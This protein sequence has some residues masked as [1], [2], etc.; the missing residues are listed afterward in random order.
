MDLMVLQYKDDEGDW[1]QLTDDLDISHAATLSSTI[2]IQVFDKEKLPPP[3]FQ[4]DTPNRSVGNAKDLREIVKEL[5]TVKETVTNLLWKLS[6]IETST[7]V[8]T[9]QGD[10]PKT[11]DNVTKGFSFCIQ[12]II[13]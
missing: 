11:Q 9:S 1:V 4:D 6:T 5:E 2:T 7:V 3:D 12:L 13:C 10:E 8:S